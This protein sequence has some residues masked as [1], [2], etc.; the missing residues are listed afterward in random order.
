M[1]KIDSISSKTY[2]LGNFNI[3]LSLN[4]STRKGLTRTAC[5]SVT[6]IDHIL[7]TYPERVTQKG[8]IDV[9]PSTHFFAQEKFLGLIAACT[10]ILNSA[11]SR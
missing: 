9:G 1:N 11:L 2:I 5:N 4:D 8:I 10:N 6:I 7:A 3:N